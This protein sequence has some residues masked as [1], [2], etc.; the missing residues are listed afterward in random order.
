MYNYKQAF[1][2]A[3]VQSRREFRTRVRAGCLGVMMGK[4][5]HSLA[6]PSTSRT[7]SIAAHKVINVD[8]LFVRKQP[9]VHEAPPQPNEDQYYAYNSSARSE[10]GRGFMG[11]PWRI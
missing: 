10:R 5:L 7:R 1:L 9:A 2:P 3:C 11:P 4:G 8:S 6:T